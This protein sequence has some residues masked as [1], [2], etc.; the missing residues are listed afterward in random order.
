METSYRPL[1]FIQTYLYAAMVAML[2]AIPS[3]VG[4]RRWV[5]ALIMVVMDMLMIANLMYCRTYFVAI[6]P[7]SYL[8]AGN[9]AEFSDSIVHSIRATDLLL[10]VVCGLTLYFMG[11]RKKGKP[12]WREFAI[13][14]GIGIVIAGLLS[15]KYGNPIAHI[16]HLKRE[17][18]Y[19]AAPPVT[20]TLP[21]S[22]IADMVDG[23]RPVSER[24]KATARE[25]LTIHPSFQGSRPKFERT[26]KN[27]VLIIVESLEGWPIGQNIEGQEIT[28]NLNKFIADSTT[29][30]FATRVQ[31]Q[32]GSGRS[33]EGQ[34]LMTVGLHPDR[35]YVYS[36][37]FPEHTYPHLATQLKSNGLEKSYF[38]SGDRATAWNQGAVM[39]SFGFDETRFRDHWDSSEYFGHTR[40]PSDKSFFTQIIGKMEEG[41]LWPQGEHALVEIVTYSGHYPFLIP[42]DKRTIKLSESYPEIIKG[43]IEAV[44][45]TDG[46]IGM[47]IEYLQGRPDWDD[48]MVV[49]VGDHEGLV[50]YRNDIRNA[51]PELSELVSDGM[52]VPMIAINAPVGGQYQS[53]MGQVDVYSTILDMMGIEGNFAGMGISALR[54]EAPGFA[55]DLYGN[56]VGDTTDVSAPLYDHIRQAPLASEAIIRADLLKQKLWNGL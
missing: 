48:T 6:P 29:T 13:Y 4:A 22:I 54:P 26:P 32:V 11:K 43:Y 33:I 12:Q 44:N 36:M 55:I 23:I 37:Q 38:L 5:Q 50:A 41:E 30:W 24:E 31:S 47:F 21:L 18:Y 35:D 2:M 1:S 40:N 46:A 17:C 28:P 52:F 3:L 25:W 53:V 14:L 10:F 15:I 19:R 42:E 51:S 49:V 56:V 9:V 16:K 20:Y 45:Y 7:S 39:G 34:L 27:L 8:L